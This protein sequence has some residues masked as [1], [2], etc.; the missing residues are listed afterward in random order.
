M[1]TPP[2]RIAIVG[3]GIGGLTLANALKIKAP[4]VSVQIFERDANEFDRSQG[5]ALT[6]RADMGLA[7]LKTVGLADTIA[8]IA[9]ATRQ[10]SIVTPSGWRLMTLGSAGDT[11]SPYYAAR[12]N[13]AS[14]RTALLSGVQGECIHWNCHAVGYEATTNGARVRFADGRAPVEADIVVACDGTKSK[15]R[16]QMLGDDVNYMN[17]TLINGRVPRDATAKLKTSLLCDEST[18]FVIGDGQSLFA[19][20]NDDSQIGW[21]Y[22]YHSPP[23]RSHSDTPPAAELLAFVRQA[24]KSWTLPPIAEMIAASDITTITTRPLI[25]R[26]CPASARDGRVVLLGDAA[27][28]MAPYMGLGANSAMVDAVKLADA[29]AAALAAGGT[30]ADLDNALQSFDAEMIPRVTAAVKASRD[31]AI[32]Y[33]TPGWAHTLWRNTKLLAIGWII[34][35]V[36]A[37]MKLIPKRPSA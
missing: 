8:K 19:S 3:G 22:A 11:R 18:I 37:V 6:L 4:T 20:L 15:L 32:S 5:F 2:L 13:R 1:S 10:F 14:L 35:A 34:S 12:V 28:P 36:M 29:L 30:D 26:R 33:H 23:R 17:V 7:A 16:Q 21:S 24:V 9:T 31:A 27:H 25:D